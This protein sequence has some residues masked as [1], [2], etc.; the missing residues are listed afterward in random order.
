MC[1]LFQDH[2]QLVEAMVPQ[3]HLEL[4]QGQISQGHLAA[5]DHL[6]Q[7]HNFPPAVI[8]QQVIVSQAV[9]VEAI[10]S[11]VQEAS[12]VVQP[13]NLFQASQPVLEIIK[14]LVHQVL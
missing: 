3:Q 12:K 4:I 8:Q 11:L 10:N 14:V 5:L 2:N 13:V 9:Q 1:E 7:E 6:Y